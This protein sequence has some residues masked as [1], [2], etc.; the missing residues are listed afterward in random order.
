MTII[1][2]EENSQELFVDENSIYR[3]STEE[4]ERFSELPE[5]IGDGYCRD[6]ELCKGLHLSIYDTKLCTDIINFELAQTVGLNEFKLK[7]GF[8][9]IFGTTVFKH[10]HNCRMEKARQ[11]LEEGNYT[12]TQVAWTVG[13]ANRGDFA[14]AFRRKFG[15]NPSIYLRKVR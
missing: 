1:S 6:F 9:Q 13:F 5:D 4:F 2:S 3:Q 8:R 7:N 12:V 14:A 10:L 15:V 11:L